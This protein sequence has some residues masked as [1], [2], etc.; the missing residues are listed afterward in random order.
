MKYLFVLGRNVELS[1]LELECFFER[2]GIA[3]EI[4]KTINNGVLIE[5]SEE[6]NGEIIDSLGGVISIGKVLVSGTEE[7]MIQELE[8]Q[9]LYEGKS[10]K[11]NYV[12]LN[13]DSNN[14]K[15]IS[16]YLKQRFRDEGLKATIKSLGG[17]IKMQDGKSFP[18][19]SSKLVNER[20]FVFENYFG[21][22]ISV[23][24][25]DSLEKRDMGKPV[26]RNELSISPRLAKIM[27]NLSQV[28]KGQTLLDPFCG[29][30]VVLQESLLQGINVVGV[31]KDKSA[32]AG[33]KSNLDWFGF[34]K[35]DY[36]LINSDSSR[37]NISLVDAIVTEPD[38]GA[39]QK[40]SVSLGEAKQILEEFETLM[41][42][43]LN[44]LKKSV[45]GRIVFTAPL[46]LTG[47][48]R[49]GCNFKR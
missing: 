28:E 42:N 18:T 48:K 5:V 21:R 43:V 35:K 29:I 45:N 6:L 30:G 19:V 47:K 17:F 33:A 31:D 16:D 24:D 37:V 44:N 40:K 20:Y 13:F 22:I 8:S 2:E 41:I 27:I 1:T 4:L 36:E 49:V 7:K 39:L 34:S 10:N 32:I 23:C 15:F 46:I 38:L 26:R 11:L 14:F 12:I 9:S 3:F 25:Y